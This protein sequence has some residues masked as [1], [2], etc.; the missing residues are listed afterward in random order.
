MKVLFLGSGTSTGVPQIGCRCEVCSSA[1]P[2]NKRLRS[3]ILLRSDEVSILVD[4]SPDLR[5]QALRYSISAI[6]AVLYTHEHLDHTAGFD[7]LRAF[8]WRR[9]ERLPLYAGELCLNKL[10]STYAWA[11][12][13]NNNY[14]GYVR[15][16]PHNHRGRPFSIADVHVLPVPVRHAAVETYGYVFICNNK[17]FA[18][19]PDIKELP[20]SSRPLLH[21]LDALAMDGL[22]FKEHHTHLTI[23]ENVALMSSLSPRRGFVT[24]SGH[25]IDYASLAARLPGFMQPAYDGLE[26]LI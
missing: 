19:I 15:P 18:Y 2:R 10:S 9:E 6:D 16:A 23:D 13:P 7:D 17:R 24:H 11:F 1:D 20:A 14:R 22:R 4:S 21:G 3:S 12:D 26:I 8:C 5:Q 25:E